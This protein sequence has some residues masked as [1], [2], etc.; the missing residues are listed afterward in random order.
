M[1][2]VIQVIPHTRAREGI[3]NCKIVD[4]IFVTIKLNVYTN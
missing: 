3:G 2:G 4:I 1:L